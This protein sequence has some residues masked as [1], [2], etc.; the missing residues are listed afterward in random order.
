VT[1]NG[2]GKATSAGFTPSAL[3][4][5]CFRAQYPG[6]TNYKASSDGSAEECFTVAQPGAPIASIASPKGAAVYAVGQ[7]VP[8][9][10]SCADG[11]GGLGI[12]TCTG[13]VANGAPVDTSTLGTHTF[14]VTAT[15]KG[16]QSTPVHVVYTV[17]AAPSAK[18]IS[19]TNGAI[20]TLGQPVVENFGCS[21]GQFGTG[22]AGCSA[23]PRVDTNSLGSFTFSVTATSNDGQSSTT[24]VHYTVVS[25]SNMFK[26]K[27]LKPHL[28]GTVT[29]T[30][31]VPG[32]GKIAIRETAPRSALPHPK[33]GR[34]RFASRKLT[35]TAKSKIRVTV[36]PNQQGRALLSHHSTTVRLT[37]TVTFTP[38][39]GKARTKTFR[40]LQ[41]TQ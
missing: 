39:N 29:F 13:N 41:V 36:K 30:L 8:A 20:Y 6:D 24:T 18:I 4:T 15:S 16:G 19:P 1:L 17:A 21:E 22:L 5:Y 28:D 2:S 33:R 34:L 7:V 35:S 38:I 25:P 32:G 14:T 11:T 3:G 9:S 27:H 37:L 40:G 12:A 31:T 23:P 10:Y 26:V